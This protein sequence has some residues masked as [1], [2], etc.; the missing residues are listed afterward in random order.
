MRVNNMTP[1]E[2]KTITLA[3]PPGK[4]MVVVLNISLVS[5]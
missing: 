5:H 1:Y 3:F 2:D 4:G